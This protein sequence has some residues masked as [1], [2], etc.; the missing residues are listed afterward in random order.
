M[1]GRFL[2]LMVNEMINPS[3]SDIEDGRKNDKQDHNTE[4]A[5]SNLPPRNTFFADGGST[6]RA[7]FIQSRFL[8][9]SREGLPEH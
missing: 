1:P 5:Y 9:L 2:E 4:D 7:S 6:M 3:I 8:H